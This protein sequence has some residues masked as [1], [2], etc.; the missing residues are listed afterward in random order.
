MRLYTL[1]NASR[2]LARW[3]ELLR[4]QAAQGPSRGTA[5]DGDF[6]VTQWP[7]TEWSETLPAPDLGS[8]SDELPDAARR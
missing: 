1:N 2:E 6:P 8:A 7:I 3:G 5:R 4:R